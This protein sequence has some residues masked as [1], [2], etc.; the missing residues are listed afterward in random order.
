MPRSPNNLRPKKN[1]SEEKLRA[2]PFNTVAELEAEAKAIRL[3][4]WRKFSEAQVIHELLSKPENSFVL[5]EWHRGLQAQFD[6]AD[7]TTPMF[8]IFSDGKGL[9]LELNKEFTMTLGEQEVKFFE[10]V[11]RAGIEGFGA[12][13]MRSRC[14][15]SPSEHNVSD[16]VRGGSAKSLAKDKK[17]VSSSKTPR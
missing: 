1:P 4:V 7:A 3:T 15:I 9:T 6:G 10:G 5:E 14:L 2:T 13:Y 8:R 17:H 12:L 11:V 16:S